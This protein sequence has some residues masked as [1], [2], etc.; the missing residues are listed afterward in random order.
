[1]GN[2]S[3]VRRGSWEMFYDLFWYLGVEFCG[4]N[5]NI[6]DYR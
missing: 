1:M 6:E 4:M 3:I 2:D 5:L